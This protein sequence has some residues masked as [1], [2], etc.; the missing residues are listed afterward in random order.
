[1][2]FAVQRGYYTQQLEIRKALLHEEIK[3]NLYDLSPP[4]VM[5]YN[6]RNMLNL[7][8][9]L[10]SLKRAPKFWF[11]KFLSVMIGLEFK[12]TLSD[13][14]FFSQYDVWLLMYVDYLMLMGPNLDK[15]GVAIK[16]I[17]KHLDVKDP[18]S[19]D[20]FSGILFIRDKDGAWMS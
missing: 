6:E 18:G 7:K 16:D 19:L 5:S 2:T 12:N 20:A 8:E 15:I 3:E 11:D 4:G 13:C 9:G 17:S 14:C 1:M 10:Y